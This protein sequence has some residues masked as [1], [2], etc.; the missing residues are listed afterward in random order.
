I[1][2]ILL[3]I[4]YSFINN[5][6][7]ENNLFENKEIAGN[8]LLAISIISVIACFGNFSFTYGAVQSKQ[9]FERYLA[10]FVTAFLMLVIGIS[11]IFT[12]RLIFILVG[13]FLVI[14][15][16]LI[17]L[18]LACMGYDFWDLLRAKK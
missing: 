16:T 14:D 6:M 9:V 3:I 7:I 17:L 1:I 15:F 5:S 18:F 10:H 13:R 2:I 12:S 8:F 11:L 4:L